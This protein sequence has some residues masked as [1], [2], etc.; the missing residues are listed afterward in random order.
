MVQRSSKGAQ[1]LPGLDPQVFA[2][3]VG[4]GN[5]LTIPGGGS[6]GLRNLAL[7]CVVEVEMPSPFL[8][9]DFSQMLHGKLGFFSHFGGISDFPNKMHEVWV[10]FFFFY[11]DLW[12]FG[13][14]TW[15][16]TP[17][18]RASNKLFENC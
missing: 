7:G 3:S 18:K 15:M 8:G 11:H 13:A 1:E 12:I 10:V 6:V 5:L 4:Q 9:G 2:F 17:M 14:Q 16:G